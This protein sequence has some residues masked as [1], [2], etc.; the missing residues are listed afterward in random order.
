MREISR[1]A[2]R[3][4]GA[5]APSLGFSYE[6]PDAR[7]LVGAAREPSGELFGTRSSSTLGAASSEVS[8]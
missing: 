7:S 3:I 4:T 5:R 8:S 2:A 1:N 6:L